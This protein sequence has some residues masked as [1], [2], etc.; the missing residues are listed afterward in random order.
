MYLASKRISYS[1]SHA[2]RV[3]PSY[4]GSLGS[5]AHTATP[6]RAIANSASVMS[7]LFLMAA[8]PCPLSLILGG[9]V[10]THLRRH[11]PGTQWLFG[12]AVAPLSL[13]AAPSLVPRP[14]ELVA[15]GGKDACVTW[16]RRSRER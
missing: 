13:T 1:N 2:L 7:N 15:N 5:R 12:L 8:T 4:R 11:C 14:C 9:G 16:S 6:I 3:L 10:T